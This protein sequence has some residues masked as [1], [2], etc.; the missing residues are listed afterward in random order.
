[1]IPKEGEVVKR[2]SSQVA[3]QAG[4]GRA[5]ALACVCHL[6]VTTRPNDR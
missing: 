3:G 4:R 1:M 6:A 5:Y 2:G